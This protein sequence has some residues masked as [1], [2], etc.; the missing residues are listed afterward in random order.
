MSLH[1]A[2]KVINAWPSPTDPNVVRGALTYLK[3]GQF[4]LLE[5]GRH[6]HSIENTRMVD[7][8]KLEA[9]KKTFVEG[10]KDENTASA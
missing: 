3:R 7:F 8:D 9:N 5:N 6:Q 2:S 4:V 1:S 10:D